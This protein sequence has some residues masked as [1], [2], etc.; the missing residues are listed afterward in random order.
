MLRRLVKL[1]LKP[2]EVSNEKVVCFYVT[3]IDEVES[4]DPEALIAVQQ[5]LLHEGVDTARI[6][7]PY[8]CFDLLEPEFSPSD[9][10]VKLAEYGFDA[11][12]TELRPGEVS[13]PQRGASEQG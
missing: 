9:V 11:T 6:Y 4:R 5:A 13:T 7:D 2:F 1:I 12:P 8:F 10:V 3:N